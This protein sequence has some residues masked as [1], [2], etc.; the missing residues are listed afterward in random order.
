MAKLNTPGTQGCYLLCPG[1]KGWYVENL[2]F[3]KYVY[4]L[5]LRLHLVPFT[6][7]FTLLFSNLVLPVD[8]Q[9]QHSFSGF[10]CLRFFLRK[11]VFIRL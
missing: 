1:I 10:S 7:A 5:A 2:V 6:L 3:N 4:L 9:R 11:R 8:R